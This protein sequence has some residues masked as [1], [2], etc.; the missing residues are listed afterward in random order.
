MPDLEVRV[1]ERAAYENGV[2]F[3]RGEVESHGEFLFG[4]G[5]LL[6]GDREVPEGGFMLFGDSQYSQRS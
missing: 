4:G 5:G 6:R 1:W 2:S 3:P